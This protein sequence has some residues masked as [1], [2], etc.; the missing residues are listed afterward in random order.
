MSKTLL[1]IGFLFFFSISISVNA[2]ATLK[3]SASKMVV[4]NQNVKF[5]LSPI[6]KNKLKE[7]YGESIQ[8]NILDNTQRLK[9][10]KNILRNRVEVIHIPNYPKKYKLLSEV[11]LFDKYNV[12]LKRETF[13]KT[14]FNPLK[15]TFDF[16]AK[17][18]QMFKV[19]NT[20]YYI[21]IKPQ[22]QN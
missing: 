1:F 19:D 14:R 6:E 22:N 13:N 9:S 7:V 17:Q 4:F 2:Q 3:N 10:I 8:K 16:Y 15:Y 20:D 18:T 11:S 21:I 12:S 5:P